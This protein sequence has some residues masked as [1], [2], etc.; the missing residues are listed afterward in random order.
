[1]TVGCGGWLLGLALYPRPPSNL[2]PPSP[3]AAP[4]VT[5]L[6]KGGGVV[7]FVVWRWGE[8]GFHIHTYIVPESPLKATE[9]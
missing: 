8:G 2:A 7:D 1:M 5:C 9:A 3:V 6:I 4:R